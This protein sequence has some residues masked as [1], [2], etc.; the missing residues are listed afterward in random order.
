MPLGE[1]TKLL[2]QDPEYRK[3]MSEVHK[4]KKF[5]E[6]T[7]TRM[8]NSNKGNTPW[9]KGKSGYCSEAT[10]QRMS[11]AKKEWYKTNDSYFKGKHFKGENSYN[12]K[13]GKRINSSGYVLIY[14][15][16]HPFSTNKGYV[17]EHRLIVEK[18]IGRYLSSEENTHHRNEIRDDNR[19]ENLMAFVNNSAHQRFHKN[20]DNVK[21][22]E[23]VF[24]GK[25]IEE[26]KDE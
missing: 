18:H 25:K 23:I 3:H 21:P 14:K 15:P 4:G 6:E 19:S 7:K 1:K 17:L 11:K 8:S 12:W 24:N 2:W 16:E 26:G 5:S 9:N 22:E 10:L 13:G 20:P